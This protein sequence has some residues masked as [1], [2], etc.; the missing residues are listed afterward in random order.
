MENILAHVSQ[1]PSKGRSME[2]YVE[3]G[4]AMLRDESPYYLSAMID[5]ESGKTLRG[6]AIGMDKQA[7]TAFAWAILNGLKDEPC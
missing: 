2:I 6:F 1:K 3:R 5:D 4:L 7:L